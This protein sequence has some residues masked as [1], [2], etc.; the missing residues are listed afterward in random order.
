MYDELNIDNQRLLLQIEKL[1]NK[2]QILSFQIEKSRNEFLNT[3]SP[4]HEKRMDEDY[5]ENLSGK[6]IQDHERGSHIFNIRTSALKD[7]NQ[8]ISIISQNE[9]GKKG[10]ILRQNAAE[11]IGSKLRDNMKFERHSLR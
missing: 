8:E 9:N 10:L 2:N 7:G 11:T 4:I 3:S 1:D 6:S 5:L